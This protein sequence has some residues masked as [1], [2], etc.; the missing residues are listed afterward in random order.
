MVLNL[1]FKVLASK[2]EWKP[3]E[4]YI[5]S[6]DAEITEDAALSLQASEN[7]REKILQSAK[8]KDRIHR[9]R[10][11]E[12]AEQLL[13]SGQV[14]GIDGTLS[15]YP[16][17]TGARCR[18]GVVAVTYA[19]QSFAEAVYISSL[20]LADQDLEDPVQLLEEAEELAKAS[21]LLF[22]ALMLYKERELALQRPEKWK[23]IH[24]PLVPLEMRLGRLGVSGALKANL[25]LAEKMLKRGNIAGVMSSTSRLRLLNLGYL[26]R[27]GEYI[28]AAKASAFMKAEKRRLTREEERLLDWF[29]EQHG[30]EI[31]V[32][33][34]KAGSKAYVFEAPANQ[35]DEAASIII[36]DSRHTGMKGF[37]L[38][39][40]YA[41][42][43]ASTLLSAEEFKQKFEQQ[44]LRAQGL[45]AIMSFDERRMR[46]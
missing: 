13:K 30:D 10:G 14:A 35:V 46:W 12:L 9:P 36:A 19:G 22:K 26:L 45:E 38:L 40:D 5:L 39:L 8:V 34:Y 4:K 32:S 18:I 23:L 6:E 25:E 44:L 28:P 1:H 31:T 41:D 20:H 24:G 21:R 17:A 3:Y 11:T 15:A 2:L 16:T 27:P 37:P 33:V 29:I 43:V 42:K 7:F